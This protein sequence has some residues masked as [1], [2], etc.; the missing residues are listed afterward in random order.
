VLHATLG[1]PPERVLSPTDRITMNEIDARAAAIGLYR[2][3]LALDVV[4]EKSRRCPARNVNRAAHWLR[5]TRDDAL[6]DHAELE[7]VARLWAST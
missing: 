3:F 4:L 5:I 7:A 1:F 6:L 2:S